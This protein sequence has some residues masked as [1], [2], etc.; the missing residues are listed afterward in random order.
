MFIKEIKNN[1]RLLIYENKSSL[2]AIGEYLNGHVV[3]LKVV[4]HD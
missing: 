4:P 1:D 3:P 2:I